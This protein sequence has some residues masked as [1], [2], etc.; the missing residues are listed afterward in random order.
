MAI[1]Y[2]LLR[3]AAVPEK[4]TAAFTLTD[5]GRHQDAPSPAGQRSRLHIVDAGTT[6]AGARV[7][8]RALAADA[9]A[10]A[11]PLE[12]AP[13]NSP[14]RNRFLTLPRCRFKPVLP[15]AAGSGRNHQET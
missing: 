2:M 8:G 5:D 3:H 10:E 7:D 15:P 13:A 4:C 6:G 12:G 11:T 14:E 1:P 9:A